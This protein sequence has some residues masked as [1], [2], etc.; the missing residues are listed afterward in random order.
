MAF[1]FG[2]HWPT[3]S[4]LAGDVPGGLRPDASAMAA[5]EPN[6][7]DGQDTTNG[8]AIPNLLTLTGGWDDRPWNPP[9]GNSNR[10]WAL[11]AAGYLA[12]ARAVRAAADGRAAQPFSPP[13]RGRAIFVDNLDEFGE[14]HFVSPH[15][16]L[17]FAQ[18][19]ALR[20]VFG[21]ADDGG[22]A[23]ALPEDVGLPWDEYTRCFS[24]GSN[25]TE[26]QQ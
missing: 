23:F 6:C 20:T 22:A 3:F 19:A 24:S 15:R 7:S 16:A 26:C 1:S 8:A 21:G 2:Y 10:L 9:P 17:G 25:A 11:D 13:L 4:T 18:L 12:A 14:G 5:I